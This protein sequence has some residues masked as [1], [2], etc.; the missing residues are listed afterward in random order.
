MSRTQQRARRDGS[1]RRGHGRRTRG[2]GGAGVR[3]IAACSDGR[4]PRRRPAS[5]AVAP[6][7]GRAAGRRHDPLL[8]VIA[9]VAGDASLTRRGGH[10]GHRASVSRWSVPRSARRRRRSPRGC[11]VCSGT[12]RR[13]GDPHRELVRRDRRARDATVFATSL[14]GLVDNSERYGW[15][16]KI[17]V[18]TANFGY[19]DTDTQAVDATLP[20]APTS[21]RGA[22]RRSL[23]T[24]RSPMRASRPCFP[25]PECTDCSSLS[26]PDAN[27]AR[28]RAGAGFC[29]CA[30]PSRRGG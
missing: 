17:A 5:G 16:W 3:G 2:R 23:A 30:R 12:V 11:A 29:D 1:D 13:A 28:G 6:R 9:F 22:W 14:T 7:S 8:L 19:G 15:P 27:R 21:H 18:L 26:S 25:K 20:G 4:G 10:A 24:R